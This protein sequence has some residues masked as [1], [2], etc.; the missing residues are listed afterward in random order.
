MSDIR[1]VRW[2]DKNITSIPELCK[3]VSFRDQGLELNVLERKL[4]RKMKCHF[5]EC[6]VHTKLK[7]SEATQSLSV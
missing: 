6:S 5:T 2:L 7:Y 4:L 3:P 1:V